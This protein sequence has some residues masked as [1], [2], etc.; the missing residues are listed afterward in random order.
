ME[1]VVMTMDSKSGE[2]SEEL[3]Q[4]QDNENQWLFALGAE[5][6]GHHQSMILPP[7]SSSSN[8]EDMSQPP[9]CA[10][11][12]Q[13]IVDKFYLSALDSKWHTTCL[14]CSDCGMELESQISCYERDGLILCKEDYLR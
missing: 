1:G 4:R 9:L 3:T 11:C 2:S 13:P 5:E 12:N 10:G 8:P 14:K 6:N 7:G